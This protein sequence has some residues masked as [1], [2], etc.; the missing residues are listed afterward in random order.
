MMSSAESEK[1]TQT[2]ESVSEERAQPEKKEEVK[3]E[4]ASLSEVD[5]AETVVKSMK[6]EREKFEE[7]VK[8]NDIAVSKLI[9]GGKTEAGGEKET[10]KEETNKEYVD[11]MRK[12]GWRV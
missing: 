3:E 2:T 8:K 4:P 11:K 6:E 7:L 5:R 1:T 10:Q 9:L 12:Q